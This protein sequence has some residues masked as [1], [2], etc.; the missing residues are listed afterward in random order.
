MST[1]PVRSDHRQMRGSLGGRCR[2]G[3]IAW[4]E[5]APALAGVAA[6]LAATTLDPA[7][8]LI[9]TTGITQPDVPRTISV[10]GNAASCAG[11][12]VIVGADANNRTLTATLAL[13]GTAV[14]TSLV[15]FSRIS[16]VELP[17]R[18]ASGNTVSVGTGA[19]LGLVHALGADVRLQTIFDGAADLGT[20]AVDAGDVGKNL[21]TPAGTLDG[22]KVLRILYVV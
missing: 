22:T 11:D 16:R 7:T 1:Y 5:E 19:G 20:L 15:A 6:V 9:V 2:L 3:Q 18:A 14:V 17:P 12:V 13:A 4:Y 21:F 10:K 8:D